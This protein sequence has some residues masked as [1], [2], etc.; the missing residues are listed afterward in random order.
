MSERED[1]GRRDAGGGAGVRRRLAAT[2]AT[3]AIA[4]SGAAAAAAPGS[5]VR[6]GKSPTTRIAG[7][8]RTNGAEDMAAIA[9]AERREHRRLLARGLAPHLPD[10]GVERID[11]ALAAAEEGAP[12]D[13]AR[14][15]G[16]TDA[17]VEAAFEAMS[18]HA[19]ARSQ[20]GA[21]HT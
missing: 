15:I 10:A 1:Q 8:E 3:A 14:R 12:G 19:L 18:R 2:A 13:L 11:H 9:R 7:S 17:E 20:R 21:G 5:P 4:M 6:S 16:A